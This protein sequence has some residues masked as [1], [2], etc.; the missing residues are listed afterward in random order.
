[1]GADSPEEYGDY[2]AWGETMPK[3]IYNW[4]TYKYSNGSSYVMTKY[5]TD[6]YYG[7]VDNKTFL[8]YFD[9]A[10]SVNWGGGWRIPTI[11]EL[12]ELRDTYNS[13]WVWTTQNGVNG[14]KVISKKN[15]NSIFL[16]ASGYRSGDNLYYEGSLGDYLSSSLS[17]IYSNNAC[18]LDFNSSDI[19]W[20]YSLRYYGKSVRAVCE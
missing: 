9:D 1:M 2:F 4:S 8:E 5:S 13:I 16:P 10:A 20:N 3:S 15:G 17:E 12:E 11:D 7:V 6:S 18:V 19:G 14:Y